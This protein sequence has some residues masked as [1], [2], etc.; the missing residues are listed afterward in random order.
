MIAAERKYLSD[1]LVRLGFDVIP[2]S[3]D[4]ILF[5]AGGRKD[6]KTKL[7]EKKILIRDCSDYY[8]LE[9]GWYRIAVRKHEDNVELIK[10]LK[11]I[12]DGT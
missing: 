9:N 12:A 11:V 5:E 6:L 4:Y 3:A 8:G 1:E 10:E 2:S 7:I